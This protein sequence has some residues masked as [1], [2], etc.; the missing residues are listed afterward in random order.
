MQSISPI[1][2]SALFQPPLAAPV[3]APALCFYDSPLSMTTR[4]AGAE[5][6]NLTVLECIVQVPCNYQGRAIYYNLDIHIL[7]S[8]VL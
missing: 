5:N 8:S 1:P 3:A 4:I 7:A 2:E 6:I